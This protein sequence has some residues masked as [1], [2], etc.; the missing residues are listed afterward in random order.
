MTPEILE[1]AEKLVR[2]ASEKRVTLCAAESCTGGLIG[3]S[4]TEI[5]GA[6][7]IFYGSAVTYH[8]SAKENI[9]G[10]TPFVLKK[11]GAVSPQ[12]AME[13]ARGARLLYKTSLA[14]S[15]TGIAGPSGGSEKKPVGTVWFG[16]S[17]LEGAYS[18]SCLFDGD[19]R[20][21]RELS[22]AEALKILLGRVK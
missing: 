20:K 2:R 22:A 16:I 12:C 15:V 3:A 8:N 1:L 17:S 11:Y 13:M 4:I 19:R 21:I 7:E 9:L 10:V 5:S 6:S 18:Y 14:V